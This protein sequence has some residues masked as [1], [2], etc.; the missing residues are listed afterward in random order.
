MQPSKVGEG[1]SQ[2]VETKNHIA[3][4][5]DYSQTPKQVFESLSI[6]FM[7]PR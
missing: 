2:M 4:F 3:H 1:R 7:V 5:E 6:A